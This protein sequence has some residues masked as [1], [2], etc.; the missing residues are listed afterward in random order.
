M[1]LPASWPGSVPVIPGTI[2]DAYSVESGVVFWGARVIPEGALADADDVARSIMEEAGF[3]LD[4][5][6]PNDDGSVNRLYA[7][8]E[9]LVAVNISTEPGEEGVLYNVQPR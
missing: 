7:N 3:V 8:D 6:N 2:V 5:Q 4:A 9:F 1:P